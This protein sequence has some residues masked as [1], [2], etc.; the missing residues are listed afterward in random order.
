MNPPDA[1]KVREMM[2]QGHW[3]QAVTFLQELGPAA[4]AN[5][6]MAVPFEEQRVLFRVIPVDFAAALISNFPYYT[7]AHN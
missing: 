7:S 2:S 6:I 1:N 5:V 3:G 4:A